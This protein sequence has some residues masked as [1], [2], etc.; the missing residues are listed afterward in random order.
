MMPSSAPENTRR[1]HVCFVPILDFL[2]QYESWMANPKPTNCDFALGNPQTMP[3]PR[4]VTALREATTPENPG[5]YAYKMSEPSSREIV[6]DSLLRLT[7]QS[8]APE[9]I[10]LTN[11]A[12]GALMVVMNAL[13]GRAGRASAPPERS[14]A[15]RRSR[16][17]PLYRR[18]AASERQH[19]FRDHLEP[20]GG[21]RPGDG[22]GVGPT[23]DDTRPAFARA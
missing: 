20:C 17:A 14:R 15:S 7:G 22:S 5:W 13:I 16:L 11:G 6:R 10:F 23:V 21:R 19:A 18:D 1:A 8:Y 3:L 4:F 2:A 12:T 9:D